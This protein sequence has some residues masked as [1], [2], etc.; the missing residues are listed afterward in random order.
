MS[1]SS[2]DLKYLAREL[3][4]QANISATP[5]LIE[6]IHRGGNNQIFLVDCKNKQFILKKYFQ[7]PE[8]KR[9]RLNNEF[10]FLQV[11]HGRVLDQTP[12][13]FSKADSSNAALYEYIEGKTIA[14]TSEVTQSLITQAAQF[15]ANL[16]IHDTPTL[17]KLLAPASE[18]CFSINEHLNKIDFRI[19]ELIQIKP[20]NQ[21]DLEFNQTL[22]EIILLWAKVKASVIRCCQIES[23]DPDQELPLNERVLSPSDF[24]F[25]NAI[26]RPNQT[27]A[28]IDFEY[29]GWDDPAKLVGDFFAQ[30][31]IKIDSRHL[32]LFLKIAFGKSQ[33]YEL[34]QKRVN[35]LLSAYKIKW[36]CIVLNIFL[37]KHL[38]RR[39]FSSPKLHIAELKKTQLYKARKL[40]KEISL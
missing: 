10:N 40:L 25:H 35:L 4:T 13:A 18:A 21:N 20:Q 39:Q 26:I 14:N 11:T 27:V 36:C 12:K 37:P 19:E 34:I 24:G 3:L 30:V 2:K 1:E 28:F 7:H 29:A 22:D 5:R 16:N 15:I 6:P 8:D 9:D 31:A 32:N 17:E 23:I 33:N 38:A